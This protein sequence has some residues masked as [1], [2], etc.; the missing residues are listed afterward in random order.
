MLATHAEMSVTECILKNFWHFKTLRILIK[1]SNYLQ[2]KI[3]NKLLVNFK[4]L[5]DY[6]NKWVKYNIQS[7]Q[8]S[9]EQ[10][11]QIYHY[12]RYYWTKILMLLHQCSLFPLNDYCSVVSNEVDILYYII[13]FKS[14]GDMLWIFILNISSHNLHYSL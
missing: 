8:K 1:S 4:H 10:F 12:Y 9:M 5:H 11:I 6:E 3:Y 7:S 14:Q 2:Q 13:Y